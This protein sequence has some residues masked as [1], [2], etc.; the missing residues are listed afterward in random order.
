MVIGLLSHFTKLG[1]ML[2]LSLASGG[3]VVDGFH[4]VFPY[5][6]EDIIGSVV[7]EDRLDLG[8]RCCGCGCRYG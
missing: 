7:P 5:A 3:G 1:D 6:L 8:G 2:E 4:D